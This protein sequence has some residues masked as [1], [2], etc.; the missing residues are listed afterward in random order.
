MNDTFK[1][2]KQLESDCIILG[3]FKL[4]RLLLVNDANYP[5]FILVPCIAGLIELFEL[6]EVDR[7]QFYQE[8]HLLAKFIK[9]A[10]NADKINI[11]ALGNVVSQLHIHHVARY[12]SD[13][14]WPKPIWGFA[15]PR[16][17]DDS[18]IEAIKNLLYQDLMMKTLLVE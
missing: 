5:W 4:C 9:T 8:S 13:I 17:Y 15:E 10:F 12:K 1:L 6:Q 2:D 3:Q 18:E 14:A 16:F 7:K 11:A